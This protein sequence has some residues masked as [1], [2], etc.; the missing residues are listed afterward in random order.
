MSSSTTHIIPRLFGYCSGEYT[1]SYG[2]IVIMFLCLFGREM[3]NIV[4]T[5]Y[6]NNNE[7]QQTR[8]IA[9]PI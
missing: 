1:N 9:R 5:I 2:N 7:E 3:E 8:H 6:Y 4:F